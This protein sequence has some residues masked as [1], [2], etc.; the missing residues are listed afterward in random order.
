[1]IINC[2]KR[3]NKYIDALVGYYTT[4][5][6]V[7]GIPTKQVEVNVAIV[8]A[9]TI[10]RL[11]AQFRQVDK[12]T[13]VLSFPTIDGGQDKLIAPRL[14]KENFA[15]EVNLDT[16]NIMLGDIYICMHKVRKQAKEYGNSVM[17]EF[18][19]LGVHG[20]LH[21]LGYDH[22]VSEDKVVM[23]KAE[24]EILGGLK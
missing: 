10:K 2:N 7:L 17:R 3:H 6:Q 24:E 11:N 15:S 14:T 16:G 5:E 19:Y 13:D 9:R 20:L 8:S 4:A 22:M 18:C 12:V 1:M 21:L 23:R